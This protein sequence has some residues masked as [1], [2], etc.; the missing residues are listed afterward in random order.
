MSLDLCIL[1]SG[2]GGNCTVVRTPRGT[3]LI[4][5][6]IGPRTAGARLKGTGVAAAD[7]SAICFTHLDRDHF[8]TNWLRTVVDRQIPLYC[9]A[10]RVGDLLAMA[11]QWRDG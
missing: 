9:H 4:D 1:A 5:A 7:A 8:S 3:V 10:T 6:G 2:S 11:R